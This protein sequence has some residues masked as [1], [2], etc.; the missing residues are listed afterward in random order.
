MTQR[1]N[2]TRGRRISGTLNNPSADE[3][4]VFQALVT[5]DGHDPRVKYLVFQS[6][7]GASGTV[8]IQFYCMFNLA[9]TARPIHAILGARVHFERSR[10]TPGQNQHYCLKPHD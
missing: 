6:E 4:A 1:R 9:L 10:G 3:K 5:D 8:H 2:F 7:V